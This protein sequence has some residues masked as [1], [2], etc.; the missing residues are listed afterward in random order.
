MYVC[1]YI[2]IYIYIY[3]YIYIYICIIY[4]Q[5]RSQEFFEGRTDFCKLGHKFLV[6]KVKSKYQ[7]VL[8]LK[9][10]IPLK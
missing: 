3:T 9:I 6:V 10:T 5:A 2:Y 7:S 8:L 1:I 4:I